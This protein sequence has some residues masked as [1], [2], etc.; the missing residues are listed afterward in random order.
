MEI[1]RN[2]GPKCERKGEISMTRLETMERSR[3]GTKAEYWHPLGLTALVYLKEAL[4]AEKYE[5]CQT[6]IDIA[7]EFGAEGWEIQNVLKSRASQ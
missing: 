3:H 5:D 2:Q 6:F 1:T 7:Q 4:D